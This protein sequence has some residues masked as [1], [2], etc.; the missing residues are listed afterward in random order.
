MSIVIPDRFNWVL[1]VMLSG[2]MT[3][4]DAPSYGVDADLD[5]MSEW[6]Q[7]WEKEFLIRRAAELRDQA[8][9]F[10]EISRMIEGGHTKAVRES[11]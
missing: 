1:G 8:P 11:G 10:D 3:V 9:R 5:W 2:L 4:S 7:K 6:G